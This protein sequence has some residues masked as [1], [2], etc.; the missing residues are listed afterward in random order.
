[1][2]EKKREG[3]LKPLFYATTFPCSSLAG[4]VI[5]GFKFGQA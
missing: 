2:K 5:L 3:D 1:M 4:V